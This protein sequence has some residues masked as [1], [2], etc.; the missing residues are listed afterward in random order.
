MLY[1]RH[2]LNLGETWVLARGEQRLRVLADAGN[3]SEG[4]DMVL[5]RVIKGLEGN[6]IGGERQV[7]R[8]KHVARDVSYVDLLVR[9]NLDN[10]TLLPDWASVASRGILRGACE[11]YTGLKPSVSKSN[12]WPTEFT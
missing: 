8:R 6:L 1:S 2:N 11:G 5:D 7:L 9:R 4:H 12:M 10:R 3:E